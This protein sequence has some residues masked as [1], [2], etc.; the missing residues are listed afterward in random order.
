[1]IDQPSDLIISATD[2]D[3][4]PFKHE[5]FGGS[6]KYIA[7][8]KNGV[9]HRK[10]LIKQDGVYSPCCNEYIYGRL[11]KAIGIAAPQYYLIDTGSRVDL[12]HTNPVVGVEFLD[13][14]TPLDK[15]KIRSNAEL[16]KD[17]I[18]CFAAYSIFAQFGDNMQC[19]YVPG[20]HIYPFDFGESFGLEN[21]SFRFLCGDEDDAVAC[22]R[23]LLHHFASNSISSSVDVCL[24]VSAKETRLNLA[25]AW[26]LF[27]QP[28]KRL[29]E[30]SDDDISTFTEALDEFYPITV[31]GYYEKYVQILQKKL[32]E[33]LKN[34]TFE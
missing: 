8:P 29:C 3:Y 7:I 26:E 21:G 20:E 16:Q 10:L 12:F 28:L 31:S 18:N 4:I 14:I 2:F 24:E 33:L 27:Q 5:G 17:L 13:N 19:A 32:S 1:M 30:L 22:A 34:K 11:L 15:E 25:T 6:N 9:Q 23:R